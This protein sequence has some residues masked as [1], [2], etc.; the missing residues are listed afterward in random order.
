M[1]HDNLQTVHSRSQHGNVIH[2]RITAGHDAMLEHPVPSL[3]PLLEYRRKTFVSGGPTGYRELIETVSLCTFVGDTLIFGAGLVPRVVQHLEAEGY[4]VVVEDDRLQLPRLTTNTALMNAVEQR[5]QE[6]LQAVQDNPLGQLAVR[7]LDA[8]IDACVLVCRFY[9]D[10]TVLVV[11]PNRRLATRIA[12]ELQLLLM[13]P[14]A[15]FMSGIPRQQCRITV[16]VGQ[17]MPDRG[18]WDVLLLPVAEQTL[19]KEAQTRLGG[20]NLFFR[21]RYAFVITQRQ[22]D[23]LTRVS[24]EQIAGPVIY[25]AARPRVPVL[26]AMLPVPQC[27]VGKARTAFTQ[28]RKLYWL[29]DTRNRHVATVAEN[30][31][32]RTHWAVKQLCGQ[33]ISLANLCGQQELRIAV[34]VESAEHARALAKLLPDWRLATWTPEARRGLPEQADSRHTIMTAM[35]AAKFGTTAQII[36]RATGTSGPLTLRGFPPRTD[37]VPDGTSVLVI[38]FDDASHPIAAKQTVHRV[39]EY[40]R[41]GLT[42]V[43]GPPFV[44]SAWLIPETSKARPS[45]SGGVCVNGLIDQTLGLI[46]SRLSGETQKAQMT[47]L[48][49]Q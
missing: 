1:N 9:F 49:A 39:D 41:L 5:E 21:R 36:I 26:F 30:L 46:P 14:V 22:H 27:H 25:G 18:K 31:A 15:L 6:L 16:A 3:Q 34:L 2:L 44:S 32:V 12:S 8:A 19:G 17:S 10:A 48:S 7:D 47:S 40:E 43:I 23:R 20:R 4:Q 24:L 29:N 45:R 37:T 42:K 11:A 28:K 35:Y 13:E 33:R 38:D